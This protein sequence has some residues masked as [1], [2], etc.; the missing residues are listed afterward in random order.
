MHV[1]PAGLCVMADWPEPELARY[2]ARPLEANTRHSVTAPAAILHRLVGIRSA[3]YAW[4]REEFADGLS[5]VAA[6]V[7]DPD[8][9]IV[10]AITVHGPSY[11]FPSPGE[12]DATA[13]A[14]RT[15][16]ARFSARG[17]HAA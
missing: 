7:R 5:S 14:V 12:E 8:G 16:A 13:A 3:G 4:I 17:H 1:S 10:G 11:R 9:V 15:A 2:L 6:P